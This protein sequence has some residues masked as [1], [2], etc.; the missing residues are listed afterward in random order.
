MIIVDAATDVRGIYEDV[1]GKYLTVLC[2]LNLLLT[3]MMIVVVN[4]C[5]SVFV[6]ILCCCCCCDK[7]GRFV[8]RHRIDTIRL[9]NDSAR[10]DRNARHNSAKK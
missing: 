9:A 7:C 1:S 3:M 5:R 4:L 2:D 6:R 8:N 10:T